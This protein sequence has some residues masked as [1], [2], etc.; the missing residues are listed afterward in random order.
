MQVIVAIPL[1]DLALKF[2]GLNPAAM[3]TYTLP[4]VPAVVNGADLLFVDQPATQQLLV[5]IFGKQLLAPTNPPPN[6]SLQTPMP[7]V[8]TPT[9]TTSV[10]KATGKKKHA[11]TTT[12]TNPTLAVPSFDPVP[13]T[14]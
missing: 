8:I 12:T 4:E 10:P 7:P 9:T 6:T 11:P 13:C 1:P 5:N 2:H 14:P 3:K